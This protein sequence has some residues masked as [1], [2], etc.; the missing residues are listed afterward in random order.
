MSDDTLYKCTVCGRVGS[1]GRC[2]G[3]E[4][5]IPLN[6]KAREEQSGLKQKKQIKG[7]AMSEKKKVI[8]ALSAAQM[9]ISRAISPLGSENDEYINGMRTAI[10][11]IQLRIDAIVESSDEE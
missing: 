9:D 8:Q 2:C 11:V 4:T 10:D 5:R 1:V 6:E 3:D 7:K